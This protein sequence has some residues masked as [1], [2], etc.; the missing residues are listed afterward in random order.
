MDGDTDPDDLVFPAVHR[1]AAPN[2]KSCYDKTIKY[3]SKINYTSKPSAVTP[4]DSAWAFVKRF[5]LWSVNSELKTQIWS[6]IAV[7]ESRSLGV[8]T[9]KLILHDYLS[10]ILKLVQMY[11]QVS[12]SHLSS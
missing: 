2:T 7:S 1:H 11:A 6:L 12:A 10:V 4:S 9:R 3:L 5:L 8:S